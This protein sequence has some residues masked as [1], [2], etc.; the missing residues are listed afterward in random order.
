[1]LVCAL[2]LISETVGYKICPLSDCVFLLL[3]L[4]LFYYTFFVVVQN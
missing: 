4:I 1:M 3:L 2:I